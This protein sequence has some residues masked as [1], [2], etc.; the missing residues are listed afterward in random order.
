MPEPTVE[1]VKRRVRSLLVLAAPGSGA[2]E[3]ERATARRL[4]DKLMAAYGLHE[5]EIPQRQVE[6]RPPPP[7]TPPEYA[8][9]VNIGGF[10]FGFNGTNSTTGW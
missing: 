7:P 10:G 8:F 9:V 2:T 3:P 4:A 6:K 1:A 5:N